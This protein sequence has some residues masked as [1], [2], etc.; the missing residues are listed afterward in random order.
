MNLIWLLLLLLL[1][2]PAS[3]AQAQLGAPLGRLEQFRSR[4]L[5]ETRTYSVY[6]PPVRR[7]R[8]TVSNTTP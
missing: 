6:V 1:L 8:S 3:K 5:G 7:I 4:L 2:V